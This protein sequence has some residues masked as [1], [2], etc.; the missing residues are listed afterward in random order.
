MF[1]IQTPAGVIEAQGIDI[2][3]WLTDEEDENSTVRLTAYPM[4]KGA[5]GYWD[6]DT[7][8]ILFSADTNFSGY[9]DEWYG[10]SEDTTPGDM[11]YEVLTLT[12]AI[13]KEVSL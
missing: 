2:N 3:V 4:R 1:N 10:L 8:T 5:D 9:Y 12:N 6:T 11:P 13:L 7:Q